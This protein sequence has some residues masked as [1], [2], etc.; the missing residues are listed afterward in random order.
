MQ[1]IP[2]HKSEAALLHDLLNHLRDQPKD[3]SGHDILIA[4]QE[5]VSEWEY[6]AKL[7]TSDYST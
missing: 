6:G 7:Q 1:D 4:A 3:S 2:T 5:F